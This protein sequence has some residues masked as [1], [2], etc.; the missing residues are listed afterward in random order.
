VVG[1]M[2]GLGLS[3]VVSRGVRMAFPTLSVAFT[4]GWIATAIVLA[5]LSG[6]I[7]SLYPSYKAARQD[8]IEALAYE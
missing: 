5:I 7:G 2:A 6:V 8:P 4:P 3:A 1:A